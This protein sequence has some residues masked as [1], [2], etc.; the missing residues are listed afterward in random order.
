MYGESDD[1]D[2]DDDDDECKIVRKRDA[3][4]CGSY[5][6]MVLDNFCA[7]RALRRAA[8]DTS[9]ASRPRPCALVLFT[10]AKKES[11]C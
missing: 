2:D 4:W 10:T 5:E 8:P 1:S 6:R 3:N 7:L 11:A 9:S